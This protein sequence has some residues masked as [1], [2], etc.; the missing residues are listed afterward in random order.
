VAREIYTTGNVNNQTILVAAIL[1][2][3]LEDTKT[4]RDELRQLFGENVLSIVLEVTD[5]KSLE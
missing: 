5:D 1:H 3:T 2:D 4:T